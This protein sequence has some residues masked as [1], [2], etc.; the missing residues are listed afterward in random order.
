MYIILLTKISKKPGT[1]ESSDV[2]S[3]EVLKLHARERRT[4]TGCDG[5]GMLSNANHLRTLSEEICDRKKAWDVAYKSRI[6]GL[7][8]NFQG[9]DKRLLLRAKSIDAWLSVRGTKVSGKVLSA[10]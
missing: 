4:G 9:T 2:R 8:N 6:K 1:P 7:V 5:R 3:V 10:T